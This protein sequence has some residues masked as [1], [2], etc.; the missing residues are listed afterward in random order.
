MQIR[1]APIPIRATL[2]DTESVVGG[3]VDGVEKGPNAILPGDI[4]NSYPYRILMGAGLAMLVGVAGAQTYGDKPATMS[5]D[6]NAPQNVQIQPSSPPDQTSADQASRLPAV[7]GATENAPPQ[8]ESAQQ[9]TDKMSAEANAQ[10]KSSGQEGR[11][12]SSVK[13]TKPTHHAAKPRSQPDQT[14]MQGDKAY[15]EALRQCAKEQ[16]QNARDSCLDNAI[17]QFHRN[18]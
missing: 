1:P 13:S 7:K 3:D 14:A 18:T 5:A 11:R 9:P 12:M 8:A 2:F 15:R 10:A 6:K 4:M 17:Q 16:D